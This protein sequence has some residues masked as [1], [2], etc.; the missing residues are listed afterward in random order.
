MKSLLFILVLR[1]TQLLCRAEDSF[2]RKIHGIHGAHDQAAQAQ[3]LQDLAALASNSAS[4]FLP[5]A[6]ASVSA[7]SSSATA[8]VSTTPFASAAVS[9]QIYTNALLPTSP[10]PPAACASALTASVA[11]NKTIQL[12]G[13]NP[14][15]DGPSLAAM[16]SP[17]C[18]SSLNA[19]RANVVTACGKYQLPGPNNVSYAPTLAVDTISGPYAVQCR[20]DPTTSK[21]CNQVLSSFGPTPAQGILGYPSNELCTPCMLGTMNATLSNPL[22]FYPDFYAVLQSALKTCG[23]AFTQYNVTKPPT[24]TVLFSPGP[25]TVPVGANETVSS[26]CALTGRTVKLTAKST[27]A[28]IASQFSVGWYDILVNNPSIQTAN[29]TAGMASGTSL[30]L[31]QTCTTYTP[32][33]NQTCKDIVTAANVILEPSKQRITVTQLV[34]FNPSLEEGCIH[35]ARQYGL[36][37]CIS[38]HGG[39]PNVGAVDNGAPKPVPTPTAIVA[40][41]GQT[42]PGTTSNCGGWYFVEKGDFC[43]KVALNNSVTLGDFVTLNPELNSECTN[44][45]AGYWYCVAAFPPLN[46]GGPTTTIPN[47]VGVFTAIT[48]S[49]PS[50]TPEAPFQFP[51]GYLPAPPNLASGSIET[52]C[53]WYY[54]VTAGDNCTGVETTYEI[55][56]TNFTA[57]NFDPVA[58]C[59][60]LT[61]GT[62]VCVLVLNATATLPPRPKNA[63]AGSA[64]SGCARWHTIVT[65]DGCAKLETDFGLTQAQ[66][67]ALNPELAPA[68]TNLALGDAYCVRAIPTALPPSGPP[69]DLNPG[70]WANCTSYYTV[71]SGDN[72]NVIDSKSN[73]S[74]SDFLH[75]NPEVSKT[76]NNLNLASYCVG[77]SGGCQS[78]YTVVSQDSC[79]V[80]ETKTG[81]SDAQLRALNPWIDTA[82]TL[83]VGQNLCIK[84]SN[85]TVPPPPTGPP[86]NLNPGSWSNCTTYYNVQSGDNCNVIDS[87]F[88]IS[89]SDFIHWNPEV[90]KTCNNLN[91]ASYCVAAPSGCQALYTVVSGDSCS[92]IEKKTALSDAQLRALNPWIDTACTLQIGQNLCTKN[93]NVAP[94][95]PGPPANLNPGSWSNCTTYYNVQSGDNC[96]IIEAKF[97]IGFSDI[98]R[99]NPEV[100]TTCGNLNLASY[101]VL[102]SGACSKLYTVVSGD[103]CGAVETKVK[104]TDALLRSENNWINTACSNIQ[105]GQNLCI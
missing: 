29:C 91:L 8:G 63:A 72:C 13:S 46:A 1:T 16:C 10:A 52:G 39:F 19:Y 21:F 57:W 53:D 88:S 31:P 47:G 93:T 9:F 78:I 76:C 60:N 83:Q 97:K 100:S 43:T 25:S 92:V 74:F 22:T 48:V 70:S 58:P 14:F 49:L 15:Y 27:C 3:R 38:P 7:A 71:I 44:L 87:K 96:N 62:A 56:T 81:V 80:I 28:Q 26:T 2:H 68:C 67:F 45:W 20:Q 61:P 30:C 64:P 65:G 103:S 101:C 90:S 24:D 51:T 94:P 32:T 98:L 84:N 18:T 69:A 54:N 5:S 4:T 12:L 95:P 50:A 102:G 37:L 11:C 17:S 36:S 104:V 99:W 42:P 66:L 79:S 34:S 82:C 75:W 41:P 59:P 23:S 77:V 40:P 35:V 85:V 6:S 105:I 73:I 55:P 89:F 86:T 33:A